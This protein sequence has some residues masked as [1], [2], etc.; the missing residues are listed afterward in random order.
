M[1]LHNAGEAFA[2]GLADDVDLLAYLKGFDAQVL[3]E[4]VVGCVGGADLDDVTPRRHPGL[5][6]VAR[7]GFVT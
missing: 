5:G 3:A 2:L 1:T 4:L 6:E 7:K